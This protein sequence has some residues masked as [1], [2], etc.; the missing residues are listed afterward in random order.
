[1]DIKHEAV[2]ITLTIENGVVT[3]SRPVL[4][5]ELIASFDTFFWLAKRAGYKIIPPDDFDT[6][7]E[8]PT[9]YNEVA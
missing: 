8:K 7:D 4:K 5:D 2:N 1:M 6:E 9:A 3:H